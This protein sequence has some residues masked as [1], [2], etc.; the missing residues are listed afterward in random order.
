LGQ[1]PDAPE[2][3]EYTMQVTVSGKHLEITPA[4]R[5][6]AE[7]KMNKLPHYLNTISQIDVVAGKHDAHAFE[8]E[9]IVHVDRH[10]NFIAKVHGEDLY[11]CIDGVVDKVVRQLRDYK[12]KTK[13][14]KGHTSAAG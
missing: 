1:S 2:R 6:F 3:K 10:E 4:I 13:T 12:E 7:E 5:K 11:G 8:V 14:H 9:A